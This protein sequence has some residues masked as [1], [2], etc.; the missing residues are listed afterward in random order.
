MTDLIIIGYGGHAK[1]IEDCVKSDSKYSILGYI[2]LIDYNNHLK[3]LGEDKSIINIMNKYPNAQYVIGIGD[4]HIR[5]KLIEHYQNYEIMYAIIK[6][7]TAVVSN[8]TIIEEG[9]VIFPMA[10]VNSGSSIGKHAILNTGS[11]IEHDNIIGSNVHIAPRVVTGGQVRIGTNTLVGLG[12]CIRNNILVGNNCII[13]CGSVVIKNVID[14][15]TIVGNPAKK[16]GGINVSYNNY[17]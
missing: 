16:R 6:H 2:D 17:C 9:T 14:G 10:V 15:D 5:Q 13:G 1:V 7:H 12:A 8:N 3:Y 11:I 4:I